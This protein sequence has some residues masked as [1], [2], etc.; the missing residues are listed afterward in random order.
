M[1]IRD[2][3]R[4]VSQ[5]EDA[6]NSISLPFRLELVSNRYIAM[7]MRFLKVKG[8]LLRVKSS[9]HVNYS[10]SKYQSYGGIILGPNDIENPSFEEF[11]LHFSWIGVK[12][13]F[14]ISFAYSVMYEGKKNLIKDLILKILLI[15][16]K[17][18]IIKEENLI[19]EL[20]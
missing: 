7:I 17:T 13:K 12:D 11:T 2:R 1:C 6:L 15:G 19:I 16:I 5:K 9:V 3:F 10:S 14:Y 8:L 4:G 20:K 18:R